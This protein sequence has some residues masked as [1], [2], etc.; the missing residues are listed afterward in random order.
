MGQSA[1]S[2]NERLRSAGAGRRVN[3]VGETRSEVHA[4]FC[5]YAL[6]LVLDDVRYTE[7]ENVETRIGRPRAATS[8]LRGLP[9]LAARTDQGSLL[10][11]Q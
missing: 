2:Q 11:G 8:V 6:G 5:A 9:S 3:Q 7:P 1:A 4:S 10:S